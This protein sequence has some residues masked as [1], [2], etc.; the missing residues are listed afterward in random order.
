MAKKSKE[1]TPQATEQTEKDRA[2]LA[3]RFG[4]AEPLPEAV[5]FLSLN[6]TQGTIR[7]PAGVPIAGPGIPEFAAGVQCIWHPGDG[8]EQQIKEFMDR[9]A[10]RGFRHAKGCT[11]EGFSR[12]IVCV[13]TQAVAEAEKRVRRTML[14]NR[15]SNLPPGVL[16]DRFVQ[17]RVAEQ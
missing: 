16:I 1:E 13:R 10:R 2:D 8:N 7:D 6:P 14:P 17:N 11:V 4:L 15:P 9:V 3:T 12:A 5:E